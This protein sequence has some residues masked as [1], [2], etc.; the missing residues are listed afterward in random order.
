M[1]DIHW[2]RTIHKQPGNYLGWPSITRNSDGKILVAF[3]G[4]RQGHVCPYGKIQMIRSGD[5]GETWSDAE[6]ICNTSLDDR[7]PGVVLLNSGTILLNWSTLDFA[8]NTEETLDQYRQSNGDEVVEG[9]IRH[10]RKIPREDIDRDSGK[11]TRRSTDGG[12]TWQAPSSSITHAPHGPTQLSDGRLVMIGTIWDYQNWEQSGVRVVEST[13]DGHSWREIGSIPRPKDAKGIRLW[14]HEPSV[15]ETR[16][17]KLVCL[18]RYQD[19]DRI[20]G[21]LRQSDSSDGGV[22]WSVPRATTMWGFPPHLATLSSGELLATYGYRRAP[23]GRRACLSTDGGASWDSENEIVLDD[24]APNTDLG[25]AATLELEP[26][27]F[28]T[29]DYYQEVEGEKTSLVGTRWSI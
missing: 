29:V 23:F 25:Y 12:A 19:A 11:W 16:E 21:Y 28:L 15:T 26:Y 18:A 27:Q 3:S 14:F 9:W 24:E 4:D 20:D 22:T 7:D 13:D 1:A 10:Y 8:V 5:E 17:G 6:T 2:T